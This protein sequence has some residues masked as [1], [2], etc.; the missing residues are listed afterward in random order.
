M[1]ALRERNK[2][3]KLE[4][5]TNLQIRE[6]FYSSSAEAPEAAAASFFLFVRPFL[7]LLPRVLRE[8]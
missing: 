3:K 8:L 2:K 5:E 1:W 6:V 7:S 4:K